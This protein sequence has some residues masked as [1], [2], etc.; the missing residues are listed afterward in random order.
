MSTSRL[1]LLLTLATVVVALAVLFAR[2]DAGTTAPATTPLLTGFDAAAVTSLRISGAAGRPV[3]TI[4]RT[5]TG[6]TLGERDGY[7][8]DA[9][10]VRQLLETL[11]ALH[12]VERKT[13]D[14]AR[15]AVLGV[16]DPRE[17]GAEGLRLDIVSGTTTRSL[18]VG[19]RA[20]TLGTYVR[21]ADDPQAYAVLPE[22][23]LPR[24]TTLWLERTLVRVPGREVAAIEVKPAGEAMYRL[25]RDASDP[26]HLRFENIPRGRAPYDEAIADPQAALLEG[27]IIDDVHRA[28]G[29]WERSAAATYSTVDGLIVRLAGR[30][31]GNRC[32]V[33]LEAATS[34]AATAASVARARN[35]NARAATREF[36]VAGW[37]CDGLFK[38]LEA[39]LR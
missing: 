7:P 14:P 33:R 10:R 35:I 32:R 19:R 27:F 26:A 2:R 36:D 34:A 39:F 31:D 15:H 4:E 25:R 8:A 24:D 6:W 23:E 30:R 18:V 37:R 29:T 5:R 38:S 21:L 20:A 11:R 12:P 1:G 3:A 13:A 28:T 22:L 9:A 17:P 16:E